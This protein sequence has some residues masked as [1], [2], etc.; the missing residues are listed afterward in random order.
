MKAPAPVSIDFLP[1]RRRSSRLGW[2]ACAVALAILLSVAAQ[3]HRDH[4]DVSERARLLA[5][6]QHQRASVPAPRV[7]VEVP[8]SAAELQGLQ[9]VS[10]QLDADWGRVFVALDNVRNAD[11]AW[12]EIEGEGARGALRLTGLARSLDAV[13]AALGRMRADPVLASAELSGH[14]AAVVDGVN[15]VR[16]VMVSRWGGS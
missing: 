12:I 5:E 15:L 1:L 9:R 11:V 3:L 8:L 6:L 2:S 16:F 13:L 4:R 7:I 14:E 10:A